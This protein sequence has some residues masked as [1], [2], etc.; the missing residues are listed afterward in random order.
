MGPI[1]RRFG[2]PDNVI[3]LLGDAPVLLGQ[4][5]EF[6]RLLAAM[7]DEFDPREIR[8]WYNLWD[9]VAARITIGQCARAKRAVVA[10]F[11]DQAANEINQPSGIRFARLDPFDASRAGQLKDKDTLEDTWPVAD[12]EMAK[13]ELKRVGLPQTSVEDLAYALALPILAPM[14]VMQSAKMAVVRNSLD[15]IEVR[16]ARTDRRVLAGAGWSRIKADM[17]ADSD[18]HAPWK[19][20]ANQPLATIVHLPPEES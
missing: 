9:A 3:E 17:D 7:R 19:P 12:H 16:H 15:D 6:F 10:L 13:Q 2:I 4:E 1:H 20:P 5:E 11:L 14:E 18:D 8:D